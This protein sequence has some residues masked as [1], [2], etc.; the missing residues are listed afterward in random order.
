MHSEKGTSIRVFVVGDSPM[1]R[2]G[3]A[4]VIQTYPNLEVAGEARVGLEVVKDIQ[5][6]HPDV[7]LIDF[8][9][10]GLHYLDMTKAIVDAVPNLPL[11]MLTN[12]EHEDFL[13]RAMQ[14][15]ARG[16]VIKRE[17]VEVI[18]DAIHNVHQGNVFISPLMASKLAG[19][20]LARLQVGVI[21]DPYQTLSPRE[22]E[23]LPLLALGDSDQ[24]IAG[25]IRISPHTL[26]THRR[27]LMKKLDL[28]SKTDVLK[29]AL[30]RGLVSI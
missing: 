7:V 21:T 10:H 23:V 3:I 28:H 26:A 17:E 1:L 4:R 27:R 8:L 2:S 25:G 19:N 16:Y 30:K 20:Y 12:N 13:I 29:Y 22:R 18:V 24:K 6:E 14:V 15:G 11:V 9:S 5:R